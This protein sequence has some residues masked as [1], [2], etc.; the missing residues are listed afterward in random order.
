VAQ[1]SFS[2]YDPN[3]YYEKVPSIT[4]N[5]VD[6]YPASTTYVRLYPGGPQSDPTDAV[7]VSASYVVIDDSIPQDRTVILSDL[8]RY[9]VQEGDHTMEVLH[10]TPFG[11]DLIHSGSIRVDR[12]VEF[13]GG[14]ISAD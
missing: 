7:L 3:A 14:I 10:E 13:V 2:G 9:F 8:D 5:L 1:A 11:I 4:L 6:L 12:T